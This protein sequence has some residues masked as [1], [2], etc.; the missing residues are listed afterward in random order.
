M[1]VLWGAF[2]TGL[3]LG[4]KEERLPLYL[5]LRDLWDNS[6]AT[7]D[8]KLVI[9]VLLE[10]H[11]QGQTE[12]ILPVAPRSIPKLTAHLSISVLDQGQ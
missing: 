10:E 8:M 6:E 3:R 2:E 5:I 1:V 7:G 9:G 4:D 11:Y 12:H